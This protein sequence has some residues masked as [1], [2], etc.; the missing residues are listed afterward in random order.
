MKRGPFIF[1][2]L[3]MTCCWFGVAC[4]KSSHSTAVVSSLS[5]VATNASGGPS[6]SIHF[7]KVTVA[8]QEVD[9][10]HTT[11]ISGQY[12]DTA[13]VPGSISIH[14]IAD[15]TGTFTANALLATYVDGQ[16]NTF[17]S[18]GD[19]TNVVTITEF[20]KTAGGTVKGSF[21]LTVSGTAGT[22]KITGGQFIAGFL[23]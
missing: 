20:Q 14:V 3:L 23:D 15:T 11:L 16:G 1:V 7:P 13:T 17:N 5:F 2:A 4:K 22:I 18:T 10:L 8:V 6:A 12:A 19:S 21:S 9:T